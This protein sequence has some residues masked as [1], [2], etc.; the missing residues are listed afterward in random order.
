MRSKSELFCVAAVIAAAVLMAFLY[1]RTG[2][3]VKNRLPDEYQMNA[4]NR[5]AAQVARFPWKID[6]IAKEKEL[7]WIRIAVDFPFYVEGRRIEGFSL[8][9]RKDHKFFTAFA[10]L[11]ESE[12]VRFY[13]LPRMEDHD[14]PEIAD[15]LAP[16]CEEV[17][18]Y[19]REHDLNSSY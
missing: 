14:F 6:K 15:F 12:E 17:E 4:S 19:I 8:R 13:H 18:R 5:D 9:V 10:A 1:A 2:S 16:R 3:E 11:S 7:I